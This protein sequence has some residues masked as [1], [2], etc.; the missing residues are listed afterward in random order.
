MAAKEK[1]LLL[2]ALAAALFARPTEASIPLHDEIVGA[3]AADAAHVSPPAAVQARPHRWLRT[4]LGFDAPSHYAL[5]PELET[6][7][8]VQE[9]LGAEQRQANQSLRHKTAVGASET[10]YDAWGNVRNQ[11]VHGEAPDTFG[12]T[13]YQNDAE[14]GLLYAKSRFY[15][16]EVGRFLNEDPLEGAIDTPPSL[17][18]YLY[19]YANPTVYFDPSGQVSEFVA[20]EKVLEA[21]E[22]VLEVFFE[23]LADSKFAE[24]AVGRRITQGLGVYL[25]LSVGASE[26]NREIINTAN[27][28]TNVFLV[29]EVA[30]TGERRGD[31][32]D[33]AISEL[34]NQIQDSVAT[35]ARLSQLPRQIK[36][37]P[38]GA[39]VKT[40]VAATTTAAKAYRFM[41]ELADGDPMAL[42]EASKKVPGVAAAVLGGAA[43][44]ERALSRTPR[45]AE[46]I[47]DP[48]TS[49]RAP[50]RT[51]QPFFPLNDG[52]LGE[53]T[54]T[55]LL[56]GERIDRFGGSDFSRFFS[57][58]GAPQASRSLPP[59]TA[60][61]PLRTFEV[62][63]PFEVETGT[64]APAF[65]E[66]GLGTQ[67]RTPV[68]L[69]VLLE[70]GIIREVTP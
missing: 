45:A 26:L 67:Y 44:G 29:T 19:G 22:T 9:L 55:F 21:S 51:L 24:T 2:V 27:T 15:D 17:H 35:F 30:V 39:G 6:R 36:E 16:P 60:G 25:G 49:S 23:K 43:T 70:R 50:R 59:G 69:K 28:A 11:V 57:P 61:Q 33:E 14:S 13:G 68:R 31:A 62:L 40:L 48:I 66:L 56:P 4:I 41:E 1:T 46:A 3:L 5:R 52:F 65:G 18:R 8:R 32:T 10:Q 53:S 37:D 34:S 58:A 47:L 12:F 38:V 20:A 7:L 42:F 64:V 54:R 63:K